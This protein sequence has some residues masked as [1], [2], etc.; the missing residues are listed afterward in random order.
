MEKYKSKAVEKPSGNGEKQS[1]ET[2]WE[3]FPPSGSIVGSCALMSAHG[4]FIRAQ[5]NG[6]VDLQETAGLWETFTIHSYGENLISVRTHHGSYLS[7][8][9]GNI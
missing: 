5:P 4:T 6:Q 8:S 7:A 1:Q 2:K 9:S 3:I